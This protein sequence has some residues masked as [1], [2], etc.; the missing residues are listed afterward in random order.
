MLAMIIIIIIVKINSFVSHQSK[1]NNPYAIIMKTMV[2]AVVVIMMVMTV[3][4]TIM[5]VM[6][7]I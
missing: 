4:M 1:V 6:I 2:V 7:V 3:L 5:M